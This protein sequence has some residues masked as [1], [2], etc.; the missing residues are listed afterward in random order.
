MR[1]YPVGSNDLPEFSVHSLPSARLNEPWSCEFS[2]ADADGD[3]VSLSMGTITTPPGVELEE[4]MYPNF[5]TLSWTPDTR[6]E[7]VISVVADDGQ[8][9][10]L[11]KLTISLSLDL[12]FPNPPLPTYAQTEIGERALYDQSVVALYD[13][14][15]LEDDIGPALNELNLTVWG[16]SS[17]DP[18]Y[19]V[20]EEFERNLTMDVRSVYSPNG[21][22]GHIY[23]RKAGDDDLWGLQSSL[24]TSENQRV[25]SWFAE[26]NATPGDGFYQRFAAVLYRSEA[27]WGAGGGGYTWANWIPGDPGMLVP[28]PL[29]E[30]SDQPEFADWDMHARL[31]ELAGPRSGDI[32][33]VMGE[34]GP[35]RAKNRHL[36]WHWEAEQFKG[37]HGEPDPTSSKVPLVFAFPGG[38]TEF[39]SSAIN[40][41]DRG[42][43]SLLSDDFTN[44]DLTPILMMIIE[45][46]REKKPQ[47]ATGN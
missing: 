8:G 40:D 30:M 23:L 7:H 1:I 15:G 26:R 17:G 12:A 13:E 31:T 4:G 33:L 21:G 10:G 24:D 6:G 35:S 18:E 37:F 42:R 27:S 46:L 47:A 29:D 9:A 2:V 19:V 3:A 41:P 22:M 32:I 38:N 43:V 45:S 39:I 44:A 16:Y 25:A 5:Y 36:A 34:S 28:V 11:R 14:D 20:G